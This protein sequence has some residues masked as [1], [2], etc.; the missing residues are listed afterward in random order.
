MTNE[1]NNN[2]SIDGCLEAISN[3][4]G[5]DNNLLKS[6]LKVESSGMNFGKDGRLI[7][8]F[9]RHIFKRYLSS[10]KILD[11]NNSQIGLM[12]KNQNDEYSSLE[13]AKQM[14]TNGAYESISMGSVQIMGFWS[15]KLGYSS[16]EEMYN[17]FSKSE[18]NVIKTFG[19]LLEINPPIIKAL[20]N[21]NYDKIAYLYNGP[22]YKNY[23]DSKGRTYADK[24]KEEYDK[25]QGA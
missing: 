16:A 13:L 5:F 19:K 7:I 4:N 25:I 3:K 23:K 24:I 21:K 2:E 6:L 18:I 22:N 15:K 1:E 12:H 20:Q 11:F 8:R 9:E 10:D 17:D 14:D